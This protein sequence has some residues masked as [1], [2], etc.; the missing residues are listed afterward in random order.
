MRCE[1]PFLFCCWGGCSH[2][3]SHR[4]MSLGFSSYGTQC[5]S[6]WITP[7]TFKRWERAC[8]VT[9]NVFAS[10]CCVVQG[11]PFSKANFFTGLGHFPQMTLVCLEFRHFRTRIKQN[12]YK[13]DYVELLTDASAFYGLFWWNFFYRFAMRAPRRLSICTP[14]HHGHFLT[15]ETLSRI[16]LS[17][18][19]DDVLR[20]VT[21]LF[22]F[23]GEYFKSFLRFLIHFFSAESTCLTDQC[24][25]TTCDK[26]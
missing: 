25:F 26:P 19:P 15:F 7:K 2:V 14:I 20:Q 9:P 18:Q 6:L 23:G 17:I 4:L 10:S 22:N 8:W 11:S 21:S 1:K 5:P 24:V 13:Q 12:T 16:S 3:K